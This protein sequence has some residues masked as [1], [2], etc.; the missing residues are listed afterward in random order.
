KS[1]KNMAQQLKQSFETLETH[2]N[3]FARFFPPEYL[4]FLNKSY[5]THI[6]LGDHVSKEM[7]VMFSDIRSFTTISEKMTPQEIFNF[8]NAYLKRVSPEIHDSKGII[9]KYLGDGLMAIFPDSADDAVRAGITKLRKLR[10][11][12]KQRIIK[13]YFPIKIGIGIHIGHVMVGMIGEQNRMQGDAL[14]DIVNLTSRLEGLTKFYGV[15]MLIS[16]QV[17]QKLNDP[18]QYEIRFLDRAAV[19][20]RSEPIFI[21]EVM[22]GEDEEVKALK[23]QTRSDFEAGLEHYYS[24]RF[25]DA[26]RYFEQVLAVNL[27]DK[28]AKLY[29]E[30]V[31]ILLESG[32][33]E[34]WDGVWNFTEK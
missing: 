27:A 11:Y 7:T 19:K 16:E 3:S 33:P 25:A 17:L 4:K 26:Q 22:D 9:V 15:S 30:R 6:Q 28:T 1:F 21:Y 14:S 32:V 12:N 31:N 23:F 20:G 13:G 34:N 8:V 29:L 2:K 24:Q 18:S 10:E 5:V